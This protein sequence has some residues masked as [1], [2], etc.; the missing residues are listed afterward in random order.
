MK[1]YSEEDMKLYKVVVQY[2]MTDD[3]Y[4]TAA[5]RDELL[6]K[7]ETVL[8]RDYVDATITDMREVDE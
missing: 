8:E 7:A 6:S 3:F 5:T 1:R 4:V 2:V